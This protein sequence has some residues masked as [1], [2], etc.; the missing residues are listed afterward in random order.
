MGVAARE[1]VTKFKAS[2]VVPQIEQVYQQLLHTK[3]LSIP[4]SS[5]GNTGTNLSSSVGSEV[6]GSRSN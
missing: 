5:L 4:S 1:R 3:V 6:L 2:S